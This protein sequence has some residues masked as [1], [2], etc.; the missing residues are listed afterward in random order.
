MGVGSLACEV[1]ACAWRLSCWKAASD[2]SK[3]LRVSALHDCTTGPV[4]GLS[5]TDTSFS[6]HQGSKCQPGGGAELSCCGGGAGL[7]CK[8]GQAA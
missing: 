4:S 6:L 5:S 8:A 3:V 1:R 7:P 2:P